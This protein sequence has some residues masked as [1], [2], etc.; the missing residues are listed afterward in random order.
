MS[1]F[2][3]HR[4]F[5]DA[6]ADIASLGVQVHQHPTAG[7]KPYAVV[8]G[9]SNARWWLI[10]LENCR[11]ASSGL[12]LFQPL[13]ASARA[14]KTAAS[15]LSVVGL[16]RLWA[17]NTVYIAGEPALIGDFPCSD[18]LSFAYFTGTDSPHRKVAV[19]IM[20]GRGNLKG[21]A[22]LTRD[23][24]VRKLLAHEAATLQQLQKLGLQ[25]A[26]LPKLLFSG[27]RNGS[28]LLV[29]DTLKTPLTRS[30]TRFSAA[31]RAFVQELAQKTAA[32]QPVRAGDIA[33]DF[34][35][36]F[37]RISHRLGEAWQQRLDQAIRSLEAQAELP[38][39]ASLSHGD[40]TPWNTFMAN[41]RLYVF[42]WEYAEPARPLSNDVIHFIMNQ[43]HIRAQPAS[44]RIEAATA[45]LAQS[46]TGVKRKT[47]P[48]LFM[49]YLLTQ[50]LLQVERLRTDPTQAQTW[51]GAE[52]NAD[53]FDAILPKPPQSATAYPQTLGS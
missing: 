36:R 14:I 13:L 24:A 47:T 3:F 27:E 16:S 20:D 45:V 48:A 8:G 29:T 49:T 38:F 34:R 37:S 42:D 52:V 39:P 51:D 7:A 32:P 31:H 43:P 35:A 44:E 1:D 2:F 53:I 28:A 30:T 10:P 33:A 11:V 15:L 19:Q 5:K 25:S 50:T 22:K 46:W 9:R 18:R 6:M 17:R 40:F 41:G 26:H 12:A 23:T 21:F 4:V